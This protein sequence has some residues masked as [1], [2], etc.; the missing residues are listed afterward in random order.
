MSI[1]DCAC[2]NNSPGA[3]EHCDGL[4]RTS[5]P[6]ECGFRYQC[7]RCD[8]EINFHNKEDSQAFTNRAQ[9]FT[10]AFSS[11]AHASGKSLLGKEV[12][13]PAYDFCEKCQSDLMAWAPIMADVL[14]LQSETNRLHRS[15]TNVRKNRNDRPASGNAG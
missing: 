7:D 2:K 14:Y 8:C 3:V 9:D 6:L 12:G 4:V 1:L 10:N 5:K 11:F 13:W 15:I